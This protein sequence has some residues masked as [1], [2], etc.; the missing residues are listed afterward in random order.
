V[1]YR[2]AIV[3]LGRVGGEFLG[4]LLN[5]KDRGFQ[6]RAV[7]ELQDTPAKEQAANEG[8]EVTTLERIAEMGSEIDVIFD[9]SGSRTVRAQLRDRL[10]NAGNMHTVIAPEIVGQMIWSLI[11]DKPLPQVHRNVGY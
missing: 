7:A 9:L 11:T 8:I 5:K 4:E 2:I 3:G 10:A 6:I 1:S